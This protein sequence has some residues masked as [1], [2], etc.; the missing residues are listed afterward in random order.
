V[1]G[2]DK[3]I[4]FDYHILAENHYDAR[5]SKADFPEG[6]DPKTRRLSP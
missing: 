2:S 3:I 5:P 6:V 1:R 4:D